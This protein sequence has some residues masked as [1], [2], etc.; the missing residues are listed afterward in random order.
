MNLYLCIPVGGNMLD[1]RDPSLFKETCLLAGKWRSAA[2]GATFPVMNPATDKIVANVPCLEQ[3]A[4][5]EAIC[6]AW[7][8]FLLWRE[9]TAKARGAV[10]RRWFD[11]IT[12]TVLTSP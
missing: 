10:L 4:I 2:D 8:A 9:T 5:E 11:L 7:Q 12:E 1:L 6:A 3:A